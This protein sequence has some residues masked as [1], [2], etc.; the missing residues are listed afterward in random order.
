MDN[1][2][3][4]RRV[5]NYAHQG[6]AKEN[7]SSTMY[8][9]RRAVAGAGAHGLEL[10]VHATLDRQLVVCHDPTVD[11]TTNSSGRIAQLTLA[12]VQSLDN[13]YW[14]V[15][16]TVVDHEAPEDA[17]IL[18][19]R[20][21]ADPDL[22]I[23]TLVEVLENF[24]GTYLN[25]DI[26]LTAPDVEPYEEL[27]AQLLGE[28]GRTDDVIVASFLDHAVA[29]FSSC[30]PAVSTAAGTGDTAAFFLAVR[31]GSPPPPTRH[32]ALQV[33]AE[34]YG[35]TV[36]DEAF[37]AAA[38][39]HGLAVHVWTIDEEEEMR[40]LLALGVDGIMTDRP[41]VMATVLDAGTSP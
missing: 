23:A 10:D 13:A 16:G 3:L 9:M 15:P 33:P 22:R 7:P 27:L 31:G 34:L 6:G 41:S 20:A 11:R 18:R 30:A 2:W 26:K 24:P 4:S 35:Q 40:R 8:A 39:D 12:E 1:P 14:W 29:T 32:H 19:G 25:L 5:L 36:V 28:F 37:V 21:P 38:H 17:Y